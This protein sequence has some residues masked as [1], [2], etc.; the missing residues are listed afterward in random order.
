MNDEEQGA[1]LDAAEALRAAALIAGLEEAK[2]RAREDATAPIPS[3]HRYGKIA[4]PEGGW[5]DEEHISQ[6]TLH[7]PQEVAAALRQAHGLKAGA[8]KLLNMGRST[9]DAYV[10]KY[11]CCAEAL[12]ESRETMKDLGEG[13]LYVAVQ[14]GEPWAVQFY[15]RTQ[16]RDRGYG[17]HIDVAIVLEEEAA[18][19]S[20]E[21]GIDIEVLKRDAQ[22]ILQTAR[23]RVVELMPG[24]DGTWAPEEVPEKAERVREVVE[25]VATRDRSEEETPPPAMGGG[26]GSPGATRPRRPQPG[27]HGEGRG[28]YGGAAHIDDAGKS[29]GTSVSH[30]G[31]VTPEIRAARKARRKARK[32]A[33]RKERAAYA[34][35]MPGAPEHRGKWGK[36]YEPDGR[37]KKYEIDGVKVPK[38]EWEVYRRKLRDEKRARRGLPPVTDVRYAHPD[39]NPDAEIDT[40]GRVIRPGRGEGPARRVHRKRPPKNNNTADA[41]K[42]TER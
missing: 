12:E 5:R 8:A 9:I 35:M 28:R 2:R 6:Q 41:T 18:R 26:A 31:E 1:P 16:A 15:L 19:L 21:T 36:K 33:A 24:A 30:E 20:R 32:E 7:T 17:D 42:G 29:Q 22:A 37:P 14:R 38:G 27:E 11:R 23:G 10:H 25:E 4:E 40:G 3:H 39:V 34:M 13:Q